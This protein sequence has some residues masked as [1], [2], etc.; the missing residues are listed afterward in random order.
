ML[1]S[2]FLFGILLFVFGLFKFIK[3][4]NDKKA[5][6]IYG[7]CAYI[8][9]G[10]TLL[11]SILLLEPVLSKYSPIIIYFSCLLILG[12]AARF[13]IVPGVRKKAE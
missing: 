2:M 1:L 13:L 7:L 10:M 8:G 6:K 4:H 12:I 5:L 9:F 11:A 3:R